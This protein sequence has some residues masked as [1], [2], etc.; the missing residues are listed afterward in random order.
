MV[1]TREI[2]LVFRLLT[3]AVRNRRLLN[4]RLD[5]RLQVDVVAKFKNGQPAGIEAKYVMKSTTQ[6]DRFMRFMQR[7]AADNNLGFNKS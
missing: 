4:F 2:T 6:W 1:E 7:Y 5:L 3:R